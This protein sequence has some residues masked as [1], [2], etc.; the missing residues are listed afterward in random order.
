ME[1]ALDL[2]LVLNSSQLEDSQRLG[3]EPPTKKKR[4]NAV[5]IGKSCAYL[6]MNTVKS[7]NSAHLPNWRRTHNFAGL[8]ISPFNPKGL[9]GSNF[10][11]VYGLRDKIHTGMVFRLERQLS[12]RTHQHN[13]FG[14]TDFSSRWFAGPSVPFD[15]A[16]PNRPE[17]IFSADVGF[18]F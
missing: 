12:D 6:T 14:F 15:P 1:S 2:L 13:F 8:F 5:C 4:K 11:P 17:Y 18:E 7:W 9:N 3:V 16:T 10:D